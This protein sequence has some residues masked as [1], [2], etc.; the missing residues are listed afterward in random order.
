MI[1]NRFQYTLASPQNTK[2]GYITLGDEKIHRIDDVH[3]F[4]KALGY[5]DTIRKSGLLPEEFVWVEYHKDGSEKNELCLQVK[6]IE[7]LIKQSATY[8]EKYA[9]QFDYWL[10]YC[11]EKLSNN[12]TGCIDCV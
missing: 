6:I 8:K 9:A 12:A 4:Y 1:S 2:S 7:Y 10:S 11:E 3:Q 5:T